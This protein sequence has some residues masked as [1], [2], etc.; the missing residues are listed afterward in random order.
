M[1]RDIRSAQGAQGLSLL[2]QGE[3]R[4]PAEPNNLLPIEEEVL[5]LPANTYTEHAIN[6]LPGTA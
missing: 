6:Y 4:W 2:Q 5:E 1:F 3:S